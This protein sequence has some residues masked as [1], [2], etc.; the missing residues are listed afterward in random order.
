MS[1]FTRLL[2]QIFSNIVVAANADRH[3][4]VRPLI[5]G[6]VGSVYRA[7]RASR[8]LPGEVRRKQF[9]ATKL[10]RRG[11]DPEEV[12]HFLNRVA[13]EMNALYRDLAASEEQA[14]RIRNALREWQT[15]HPARP[16]DD[17]GRPQQPRPA[18]H[19]GWQ[20]SP[21]HPNTRFT[22]G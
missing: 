8:V 7:R 16:G 17:Y 20:L 5:D 10:G 12:H 6:T 4:M 11:L 22:V 1:R 21:P 13:E 19:P 15:Q 18:R 2:T 14:S 9:G 3:V